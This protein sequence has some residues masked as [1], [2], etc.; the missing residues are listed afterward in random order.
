MSKTLNQKNTLTEA[1]EFWEDNHSMKWAESTK[2]SYRKTVESVEEYMISNDLEPI[3]ENVDYAFIKQWENHLYEIFSEKSIK[4]KIATMASLFSFLNKLG[5]VHSNEFAIITISNNDNQTSHS[6]ELDIQELYEVFKAAQQ[7][8]AEGTPVL[9]PTLVAMFTG[10]RSVTLKKLKVSTVNFNKS[11][12]EFKLK[13][14]KS[15]KTT[16]QKK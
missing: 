10:F 11:Q 14:N 12:L 3:I 15:I 7:L 4:Q 9:L 13:E 2:K 6:R 16:K 5:T 8:E 1:Y